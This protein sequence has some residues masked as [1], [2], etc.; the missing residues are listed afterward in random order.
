[1]T[2]D[3]DDRDRPPR[4]RLDR[5]G[6]LKG[7]A[8]GTA[9]VAA[10]GRVG[11]APA[12]ARAA[13]PV[14]DED[15]LA[16]E[17]GGPVPPPPRI[18]V[19]HP[20]SDFM[21]DVIKSL[22]IDYIAANPG[23]SFDALQESLINYGG[24]VSPEFLTCC[25]EESAVAM[26]HGYAKI[27]GKPMG[28]FLHGTI[29]IQHA[30]MAIYNAYGDRVPVYMIAGLGR[31]AVPAHAATDMAAMVR[32]FVKWDHQPLSLEDFASSAVQAYRV[33][34]TPPTAPTL[35]VVDLDLQTAPMPA[36]EPARLP[37]TLP[38][39]PSADVGS[40]TE[41]ARRLVAADNPKIHC[42][43]VA[44]SQRGIS[45]LVELAELLQAPVAGGNDRVNFPSRHPLAGPGVGEADLILNL[46]TAGRPQPG[47]SQLTISSAELMLTGNFEID[48]SPA[49]GD[50]VVAADA[51]ASLP[52]LIEQV[53]GAV[54]RQRRRVFA[55]RGRRIAAA[56]VQRRLAAVERAGAGWDLRPVSVPRLCTELW[57]LI[58]D[59]DWSLV[60]PQGFISGWPSR[61]WPMEKH[62]HYIGGQG[63]GGMGYGAPAAVGAALANRSHGRLSINIQTDGDMC[64]APAVL[65]TSAHHRIPL[66]TVMH[67]NRAYHQEVMFM[68]RMAGWHGRR[69]DRARIG[70]TLADPVIDYAKMAESF[71]VYGEGPIDDPRD[72][73]AALARG[74]ERVKR[75]EPALI[76]VLTQPR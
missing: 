70:T 10:G 62:Y 63:A 1:V 74:I 65:W 5:R 11:D 28:V 57:E 16:A 20:Q 37:V 41:I 9:A 51:E 13:A 52:E 55:E 44:R 54:T 8:L 27:E 24:N 12:Q 23:S 34:M 49:R 53:R 75:G 17:T 14:P 32:G 64:Y 7:A 26:A 2:D 66:L 68:Q 58:K 29:G 36:T 30:S 76:D 35:L 31:N 3:C 72:L 73:R 38:E 48:P 69:A 21:I 40:L 56:H 47:T 4:P 71:G 45:L 60:S 19:E 15:T 50:L 25:H 18:V 43:R 6:F 22:D 42:G 61:L 39:P 33:A 46:E 59:E 67:N